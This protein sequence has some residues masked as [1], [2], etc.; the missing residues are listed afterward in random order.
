[1]TTFLQFLVAGISLGAVYALLALGFVMVFKA[2]GVVNFAHPALLMVGAYVTAR[3]AAADGGLPISDATLRFAVALAIG[4][5]A[6][7]AFA[8]AVQRGLVHPMAA[9]S[10]VAVSI[11]TI[12]VDVVVQTEIVRRFGSLDA[13]S[14]GDPWAGDVAHV[15]GLAIPY[16]RI[17]ALV[18][19]LLVIGGF[20]AW[21]RFSVWGVAM[22]AVAEDP[23]TAALMGVRRSRV[24]ATAWVL[25][26]ALAAIAGLFISVS[27]AAG[28]APATAVV[29][30]QTFP[31]AIIGGLDS[32]GGAVVGGLVVGVAEMLTQG[33]ASELSLLGQGFHTVM[34]YVVMVVVLLVR[35]SGLF[36]TREL[37]RV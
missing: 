6:S 27:P 2:T 32:T 25:A 10:V 24:A 13:L 3:C 20:F 21:F 34:P 15:A 33:Y 1:M 23:E 36:G 16:T 35:P 9:R 29:A 31:A 17:A 18:V 11:M 7:A 4:V 30:L 37:H 12:G 5:G 28:L 14:M 19:G 22:R 8:L 26:G